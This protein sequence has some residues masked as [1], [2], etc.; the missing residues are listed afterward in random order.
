M[1]RHRNGVTKNRKTSLTSS[2]SGRAWREEEEAYLIQTRM[3]KTP[4]KHIAAHLNKTELACRLHYH[5]LSHGSTRR[6]RI[7]SFSSGSSE[8]SPSQPAAPSS[9]VCRGARSLSPPM[10][11]GGFLGKST[12]DSDM[13]LPRILSA[14]RSPRL[15]AIL[16]KPEGVPFSPAIGEAL[17]RCASITSEQCINNTLPPVKMH[18]F[19]GGATYQPSGPPRCLDGSRLS[20]PSSSVHTPA[21]VDLKRLFAVYERHKRAFWAVIGDEYGMNASPA[22]LEQAWR[23]GACGQYSDSNPMTRVG[24]PAEG[25]RAELGSRGRDKTRIA[26]ILDDG[27]EM[28]L[29]R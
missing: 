18:H 17:P 3:L 1:N 21:Q 9:P 2:S 13:R 6:K 12:Q 4:Y 28:R 15:P 16:P 11:G 14:K 29:Q 8:P 23:L 22:A 24:S 5:Q 20:P 25:R 10:S 19:Q 26:S 7:A 27:P